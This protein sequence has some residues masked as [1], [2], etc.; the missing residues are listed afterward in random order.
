MGKYDSVW[1]KE[2]NIQTLKPIGRLERGVFEP[3]MDY[4]RRHKGGVKLIHF[5]RNQP[6]ESWRAIKG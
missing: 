3:A 2:F 6:W 1:K 4:A 5:I